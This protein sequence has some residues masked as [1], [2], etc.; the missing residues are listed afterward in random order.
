[1]NL[2]DK[3]SLDA[4][5]QGLQA[6]QRLRIEQVSAL[7]GWGRSKIY[8]EVQAERFPQPERRGHRCSR[9]RAG[10]V[11]EWLRASKAAAQGAA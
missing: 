3:Q 10:D 8:Q 11:L 6:E 1:M 7:V 4:L 9:W 2:P 5:P